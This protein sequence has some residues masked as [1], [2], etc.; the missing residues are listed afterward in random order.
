MIRK[1]II[2]YTKNPLGSQILIE[3]KGKESSSFFMKL[4]NGF[5]QSEVEIAEEVKAMPAE[6]DDEPLER[7]AWRYVI[8]KIKFSKTL[9]SENW[10]HS[11][12][13][14]INSVGNGIC[15]D[16]SSTLHIIWKALGLQSRVWGLEGHVVPEVFTNGKWHM[17]DPSH[18]TYYLNNDNEVAG[19]EELSMHPE[20]ITD[21]IDK[22]MIDNG[23]VV[24]YA[25]GHSQKIARVYSTTSN[26]VVNSYYDFDFELSDSMFLL[27]AGAK[28]RF[29]L[30]SPEKNKNACNSFAREYSFLSVE[31][32]SGK[33][34][35]LHIPLVLHAIEG[36]GKVRI[37]DREFQINSEEMKTYLRDFSVFHKQI[38]FSENP[39]NAKVYYLINKRTISFSNSN[40]L[41]IDGYETEKLSAAIVEDPIASGGDDPLSFLDSIIKGKF[42]DYDRKKETQTKQMR[43]LLS[44]ATNE[45]NIAE[46]VT[47]FI[48]LQGNLNG[49]QKRE[50]LYN[51]NKR[52]KTLISKLGEGSK[53]ER[54]FAA[55]SDPYIFIVFLTYIEYCSEETM[56]QMLM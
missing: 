44:T 20:L 9:T 1:E 6:F 39:V 41:Y 42:I 16:L 24:S 7:K 56:T 8:K 2:L 22:T 10:Q 11:P 17:Y 4:N 45:N 21:P 36:E 12:V 28:L 43:A 49:V 18:Q 47:F 32:P 33:T 55:L 26:N 29:P 15:D 37:D 30:S 25:L 48:N 19:V 50:K 40:T 54:V 5:Y 35:L 3:N 38:F 51:A 46:R 13:I 52:I 27:P 14:M 31:I 53:R 23:N 34:G